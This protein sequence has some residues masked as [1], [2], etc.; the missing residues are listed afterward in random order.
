MNYSIK[1]III[2]GG[3]SAGWMSA[4]TLIKHFPNKEIT[5]IESPNIPTVGVGEST[6]GGINNW[7]ASL[8]IKDEDFMKACDATYKYA[9]KFTDFSDIDREPFYYPF[10][11]MFLDGTSNLGAMDWHLKKALNPTLSVQDYARCFMPVMALVD[12]NRINLNE[13]GVFDNFRFDRD[14]AYHFDAI[15]FATWLRT[16][17]AMPRGVKHV[18]GEIKEVKVDDNEGIEYLKSESG[19]IFTADLYIDCTGFK[20]VLL[21]QALG[22]QFIHFDHSLPN[23]KAWVCPLPYVD[24][25]KE[26]DTYTNCTALGNGWVWNIPTFARIGTGYVYCDKYISSDDALE[27]FK[28][29]LSSK[30]MTI[31]RTKDQIEKLNFREISFKSGIHKRTWVKNVCA[32]GLSAGFLEPL[33]STGLYTVHE[34]LLKLVKTLDSDKVSQWDK[35]VYNTATRNQFENFSEFVALHY[36]LSKR[37]DTKYWQ[38]IFNKT[39]DQNML[40]LKPTRT[41]GYYE[42]ANQYMFDWSFSTDY[43]AGTHFIATGMNFNPIDKSRIESIEWLHRRNYPSIVETSNATWESNKTRWNAVAESSPSHYHYLKNTIYKDY[44]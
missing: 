16:K 7:L 38:D 25:E 2:L 12:K 4:A 32:I 41:F 13:T 34:F 37:T 9:I 6:L 31:P 43:P 10:G 5:V 8:G 24:I 36:A 39:F 22:E 28:N 18:L 11:K 33:E 35:D 15:K 21:E 40:D 27:E 26:M 42:L 30:K 17:Y 3:G 20:S 1:K 44:N 23:N 14:T 19:E 29:Y